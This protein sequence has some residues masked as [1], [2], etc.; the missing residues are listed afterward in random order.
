MKLAN[1]QLY[2]AYSEELLGKSDNWRQIYKQANLTFHTLNEV[3]PKNNVLRKK[4]WL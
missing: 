3:C 2:R 4:Y 1:F